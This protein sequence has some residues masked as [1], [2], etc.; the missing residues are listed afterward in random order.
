MFFFQLASVIPHPFAIG[1]CYRPSEF[2]G[3][4]VRGLREEDSWVDPHWRPQHLLCPFCH[5]N[6]TVYG[7]VVVLILQ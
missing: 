2:L 4:V 1:T 6:F 7:H 5:V 3:Y